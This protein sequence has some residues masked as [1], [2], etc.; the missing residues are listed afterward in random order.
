M[1]TRTNERTH[2]HFTWIET[3]Q[4]REKA[5]RTCCWARTIRNIL[6]L[7]MEFDIESMVSTYEGEAKWTPNF[8]QNVECRLCF[9]R[10][11]LGEERSSHLP[12]IWRSGPATEVHR[13]VK[14]GSTEFA[15]PS[16]KTETVSNNSNYLWVRGVDCAPATREWAIRGRSINGHENSRK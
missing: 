6:C 14:I 3:S 10:I 4:K 2:P 12:Q 9:H 8:Q 13:Q 1:F 15:R 5:N 7:K 11:P 16:H